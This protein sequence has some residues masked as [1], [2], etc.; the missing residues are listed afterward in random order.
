MSRQS[1]SGKLKAEE[2]TVDRYDLSAPEAPC[3]G[4]HAGPWVV[5]S[6]EG[7]AH[8]H[9]QCLTCLAIDRTGARAKG[10]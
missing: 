9:S 1:E 7:S 10:L 6:R 5:I 4:E 8:P 3:P 2:A